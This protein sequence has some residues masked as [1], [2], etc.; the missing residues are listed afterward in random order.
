MSKNKYFLRKPGETAF[1]EVPRGV[2]IKAE[3]DCGFG[4]PTSQNDP[5]CDAF[6]DNEGTMGRIEFSEENRKKREDR[7]KEI[8][9]LRKEAMEKG[10]KNDPAIHLISQVHK[11]R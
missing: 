11:E 1:K 3:R 6:D 2:Y 10:E 5:A 9:R 4:S 8:N 7:D